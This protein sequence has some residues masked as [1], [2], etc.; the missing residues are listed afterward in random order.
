MSLLSQNLKSHQ[1][2]INSQAGFELYFLSK[3][4][5]FLQLLFGVFKTFCIASV[6]PGVW[7]CVCVRVCVCPCMQLREP[8]ERTRF[9]AP[10]PASITAAVIIF[11]IFQVTF[12][13]GEKSILLLKVKH[14]KWTI[15]VSAWLIPVKHSQICM[16]PLGISFV[17]LVQPVIYWE[18][19]MCQALG[20]KQ[21]IR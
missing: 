10:A 6:P 8:L 4:F 11:H 1:V 2:Q 19:C 17:H 21:W 18:L 14:L 20:I 12:S 3:C 9:G 5:V 16:F 13:F 7:V 15:L